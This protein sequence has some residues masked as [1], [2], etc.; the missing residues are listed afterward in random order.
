M[1]ISN[2]KGITVRFED[3]EMAKLDELAARYHVSSATIIRWALKALADYVEINNGRIV[4]P[5]DFTTFYQQAV[6]FA[7]LKVA[8]DPG[9]AASPSTPANSAQGIKYPSGRR[10]KQG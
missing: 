7:E 2:R 8:D 1:S 3:E 5:L 6:T 4:L 10:K 9:N